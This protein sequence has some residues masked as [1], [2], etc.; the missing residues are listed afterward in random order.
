MRSSLR[1]QHIGIDALWLW[2]VAQIRVD[3][4]PRGPQA[5]SKERIPES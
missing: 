3:H 2:I 1:H 4:Q 5:G